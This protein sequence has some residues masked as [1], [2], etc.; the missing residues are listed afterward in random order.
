MSKKDTNNLRG[1][2]LQ[3]LFTLLFCAVLIV[4]AI[5]TRPSTLA[6]YSLQESRTNLTI[7]A[8]SQVM[9]NALRETSSALQAVKEELQLQRELFEETKELDENDPYVKAE[10]Y[11]HYVY[12]IVENYY[13]TINPQLVR[14]IIHH[15]SRYDASKVNSKTNATG[16]MQVLPK[17]HM[18]RAESLGVTNLK[19]PYGNILVGCD[20]L[21]ELFSKYSY[22]YA[23]D[24]YAG[25][26]PY[27]NK[28]KGRTSKYVRELDAIMFGLTN[29]TIIPGGG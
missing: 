12:E 26:Y 21:N 5:F 18:K 15:E 1:L 29:G 20:F 7:T 16:L 8:S 9:A 22:N 11:D 23:L 3:I 14:A 6:T 19:D 10:I 25:G 2:L 13:P 24:L 17:W 4:Y 28:N 27:A